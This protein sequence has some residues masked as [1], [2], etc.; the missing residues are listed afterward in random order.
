[1]NRNEYK[2]CLSGN[3]LCTMKGV[4][5]SYSDLQTTLYYY[6]P[7]IDKFAVMI[8]NTNLIGT[9]HIIFCDVMYSLV[10]VTFSIPVGQG[11][12]V[13]ILILRINYE[14][15]MKL[16]FM[17]GRTQSAVQYQDQCLI[18]FRQIRDNSCENHT[19]HTNSVC[20]FLKRFVILMFMTHNP[21]F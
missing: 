7:F 2:R 20:G 18:L 19:E 10:P 21:E 4:L 13:K 12:L 11:L 16:R 17:P 6:K 3:K 9:E 15:C 8:S 14:L 1:M 5:F